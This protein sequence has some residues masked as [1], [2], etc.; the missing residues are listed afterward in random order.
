MS[1]KI[2]LKAGIVLAGIVLGVAVAYEVAQA[3]QLREGRLELRHSAEQTMTAEEHLAAEANDAIAQVADDNLTFCSDRELAFMRAYIFRSPHVR[4]LGRVKEGKLYCSAAIGRLAEPMLTPTPTM[5]VDGRKIYVNI[6]IML[7]G[8]AASSASDAAGAVLEIGSVSAVMNP[9]DFNNPNNLP[10]IFSGMLLDRSRKRVLPVLGQTTPLTSEEVIAGDVIERGG[11]FYQPICS[12]RANLC[13]IVGK[14]R[15]EMLSSSQPLVAGFEIGGGLL[16]GAF[17]LIVVQFYL[18]HRSL[19]SQLRRAVRRHT[20]TLV[21]Q[22][23]VNLQTSEI[24]GAEALVRWVNEQGT[25]VNPEIF[26]ALAEEQG[27]ITEITRLVVQRAVTELRD[28]LL[29]GNFMVTLNIASEDLADPRFYG[30]LQE[31]LLKAAVP[32]SSI[33][34]ELTERSTTDQETAVEALAQLK[35]IGHKTYID[36]FGTGFSSL[37]YLHELDVDG[38]K[39]DQVFTRSVGTEAVTASVVPQI[40][41]MA[42][43]L[44]LQVVVEGIETEEQAAYFRAAGRGVLG[45]GWLFGKPLA[46]DRFREMYVQQTEGRQ[47]VS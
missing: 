4:D 14:P 13:A 47:Q 40:L 11:I 3:I 9:R 6:R 21:Y 35:S 30:H 28:L 26:V 27:F 42:A 22:P 39:I 31:C 36:D 24:V 1:V 34:I 20:L 7:S 44:D 5:V 32:P 29:H 12:Q 19:E 16:G 43:R 37:A 23:V 10:G 18:R 38:I 46:A 33:G 17:A 15:A 41:E 25:V 2:T 45:Q 8:D